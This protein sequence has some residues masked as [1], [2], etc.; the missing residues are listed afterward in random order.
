MPST[1]SRRRVAARLL[2]VVLALLATASVPAHAATSSAQ[3]PI[4][5]EVYGDYGQK[6]SGMYGWVEFN[7]STTYTYQFYLCRESSYSA[8][9]GYV[10][11]NDRT[12]QRASHSLN[13]GDTK[14]AQCKYPARLYSR[15]DYVGST[16]TN[17]TFEV[18]GV[19][20]NGQNQATWRRN[21]ATY[22]NPFN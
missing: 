2:T 12:V 7:D 13:Y 16:V 18:E 11:I 22:D 8:A 19:N 5:L 1:T 14:I 6:L 15:T 4:T 21:S 20:F 17:V 10:R 3:V 9:G